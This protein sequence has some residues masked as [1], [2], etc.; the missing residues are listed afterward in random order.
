MFMF[1]IIL[2][3]V[4]GACIFSVFSFLIVL[5]SFPGVGKAQWGQPSPLSALPRAIDIKTLL[6]CWMGGPITQGDCPIHVNSPPTCFSISQSTSLVQY[7]FFLTVYVWGFLYYVAGRNDGLLIM[8]FCK[9]YSWKSQ[10]TVIY[11][12]LVSSYTLLQMFFVETNF[13]LICSTHAVTKR[14][15]Q[16]KQKEVW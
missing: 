7:A 15:R 1:F 4:D 9:Y 16:I 3:P 6:L 5:R 14:M 13:A 2:G 10:A 12:V 11:I 8:I